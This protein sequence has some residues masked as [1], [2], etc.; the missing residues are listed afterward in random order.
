M[1]LLPGAD[2]GLAL[3]VFAGVGETDLVLACGTFGDGCVRVC[4]EGVGVEISVDNG[5]ELHGCSRILPLA[6]EPGDQLS[7]A[8]IDSCGT[9]QRVGVAPTAG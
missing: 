4:R 8:L 5:P 3:I 1:S 6:L 9:R 7:H 2:R